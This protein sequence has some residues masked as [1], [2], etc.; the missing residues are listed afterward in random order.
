MVYVEWL[1]VRGALKWT[2]IVLGILFVL[3]CIAR[4]SL[5]AIPHHAMVEMHEMKFGY[6]VIVGAFVALIVATVLGAPFARENDGHLEVAL[7]K[8][9]DRTA[10]ALQTIGA[11]VAGIVAAVAL[12]TVFGIAMHT[13]FFPPWITFHYGDAT[14]IVMCIMSPLAWYAMLAAATAS[15]KRGYGAIQ[16][17]AWPVAAIVAGL[18]LIDGS[19]NPMAALI[20]ATFWTLSRIDPLV[21]MRIEA[22]DMQGVAD[23]TWLPKVT[24]LAVLAAGYGVL[25]I[26]QWRRVEA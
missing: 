7:T 9:I 19:D 17:I 6:F 21:Y 25:A 11:D 22:N 16:G 14:A 3:T 2:A 24:M 4:V 20:H 12:G 18:S 8:P 1:R 5:Q 26:V 15:L 23:S 10:L 13:V